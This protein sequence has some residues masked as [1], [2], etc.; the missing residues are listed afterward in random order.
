M[1]N[2]YTLSICIPTYELPVELERLLNSVISQISNDIENDVEIVVADGSRDLTTEKLITSMFRRPYIHYVRDSK[3]VGFDRNILAVTK[4]ARGKFIWWIGDDDAMVAGGLRRVLSFLRDNDISFLFVNCINGYSNNRLFDI[5]NDRFFIDGSHAIE[6]I[7]CGLG[8]MSATIFK[9]ELALTGIE[10]SKNILGLFLLVFIWFCTLYPKKGSMY[11]MSDPAI[12]NFPETSDK[13]LVKFKGDDGGINNP[14]FQIFGVNFLTITMEFAD[15]FKVVSIKKLLSNSL[16]S[17][18]R[19]LFVAWVGGWDT[20]RGKRWKMFKLYRS[21]S[22][23]WL[24]WPIFLLPLSV[25]K[26]LYRIYK[27]F[28]SRRKWKFSKV[29][30]KGE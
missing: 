8:F 29:N 10:A 27:I 22:E 1:D 23:I 26:F 3:N 30:T 5:G 24:V 2:K 6:E 4:L 7:L 20:P 28:F 14:F 19:G 9:R 21:F 17:V 16:A 25:N 12:I 11:Y 13:I 15:K 18:W